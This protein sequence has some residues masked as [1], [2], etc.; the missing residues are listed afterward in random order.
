MN[1][2]QF[3]FPTA[4]WRLCFRQSNFGCRSN[5]SRTVSEAL[6]PPSWINPRVTAKMADSLDVSSS[7]ADSESFDDVAIEVPH[8]EDTQIID[9]TDDQVKN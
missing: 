7:L 2:S 5:G 1:L 8:I 6:T 4:N 3:Q 9:Q